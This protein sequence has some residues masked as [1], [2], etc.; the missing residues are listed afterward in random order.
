MSIKSLTRAVSG[1]RNRLNRTPP[2]PDLV[3]TVEW[4][5]NGH[6]NYD[7]P[8]CI[9]SKASRVGFPSDET[10]RGIVA[11]FAK[12]P[13]SWEIK[14]SGGEPFAFKGFINSVIPQLVEKTGH[15]L[16]VLTNFSAPVS[17]LRKFCELTGERLRITSASL[18]PDTISIDEFLPKAIQYRDFREQLN[19]NSSFVINCVL[20]P[21]RVRDQVEF[22]KRI[23]EE[24]FRYFPQLMKIKGGVFPYEPAEVEL[25]E[26]QTGGSHDPHAVNRSPSYQG[27][28]C[29]A[30]AWY[31][32]VDQTGQAYTCR[33]GKRFLHVDDRADMGNLVD[34]TFSLRSK[35]GRCP[36][37]ICPCTVPANRGVVRIPEGFVPDVVEDRNDGEAPEA[38]L[39][40]L[41]S[42]GRDGN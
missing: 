21:G 13:A 2:F 27:L 30:G 15:K 19:P 24:G 9:Q 26:E 38:S 7:C 20:V 22:Q 41:N 12:L 33:T 32:T 34:G 6:C 29:E 42:G 36:Y 3:P 4:Q 35:G 23:E 8:Y 18:H 28:H 25:I 11:A 10:I 5:V 17:V 16:S 40:Q 31:F 37:T 39:F 1:L 14:M